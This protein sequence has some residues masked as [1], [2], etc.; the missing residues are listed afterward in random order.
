MLHARFEKVG[1][2]EED[3]G[4]QARKEASCELESCLGLATLWLRTGVNVDTF[5]TYDAFWFRNCTFGEA[6]VGH[7]RHGDE[8][9]FSLLSK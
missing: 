4:G 3:R 5:S 8:T 6:M 7:N 2:L 1:R 9:P